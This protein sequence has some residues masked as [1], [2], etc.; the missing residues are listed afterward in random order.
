[1][2]RQAKCNRIILVSS[3]TH[4]P[5]C[6]RDACSLW[7]HPPAPCDPLPSI[8]NL[9][10][11]TP[12]DG[13]SGGGDRC[14]SDSSESGCLEDKLR[15]AVGE[16]KI[17]ISSHGKDEDALAEQ[18]LDVEQKSSPRLR[19]KRDEQAPLAWDKLVKVRD[20]VA[21]STTIPDGNDDDGHDE[22]ERGMELSWRPVLLASP[23]G[24]SY[25]D[26]GPD[27]VAIV[28]PPHRGDNDDDRFNN[29][30]AFLETRG[31]AAASPDNRSQVENKNEGEGVP[32]ASDEVPMLHELVALA[33]R[34][35]KGGGE[36][37]RREFQAL[38]RRHL[39]AEDV[40]RYW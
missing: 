5:R 6:L 23:S 32:E 38:L 16:E 28:E 9:G 2:F 36:R 17:S 40:E 33:L 39:R 26:C 10:S 14:S 31:R 3:P 25:A 1:M 27:D 12:P 18:A 37:F 29:E 21:R 34:V 30:L 24:A 7:L 35:P 4:L 22:E 11:I 15:F 20:A 19:T 13:G 8:G